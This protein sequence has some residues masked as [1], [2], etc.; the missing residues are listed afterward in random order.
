MRYT[1]A[2]MRLGEMLVEHGVITE[3]QLEEALAVQARRGGK[4]AE[5]LI[6]LQHIDHDA[7]ERVVATQP[8]IASVDLTRYRLSRELCEL[9]PHEFAAKHLVF[10]ID[11]M[12][13][14]LTVGMA[15]PLDAA[16]IDA[17]R[18][19]TG[20]RVKVFYCKPQAIEAAIKRYYRPFGEVDWSELLARQTQRTKKRTPSDAEGDE[21]APGD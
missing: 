18:E 19:M 2:P 16:T 17:I 15:M 1:E 14:T 10:P 6:K 12:G 8:G 13:R 11:K 7:L 20:M 21:P 4:L 3:T 9:I 5:V